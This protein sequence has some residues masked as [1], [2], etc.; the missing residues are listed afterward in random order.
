V[1]VYVAPTPT[2]AEIVRARLA[3]YGIR[4]ALQYESAGRVIGLVVDGWGETRVLVAAAQADEA[5]AILAD[6][7]GP[8]EESSAGSSPS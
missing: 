7:D 4:A 8:E 2:I 5:R 3:S 6:D 1:V